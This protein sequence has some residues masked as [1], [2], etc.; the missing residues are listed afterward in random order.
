MDLRGGVVDALFDHMLIAQHQAFD[1]SRSIGSFS[2][3][4]GVVDTTSITLGRTIYRSSSSAYPAYGTLNVTGGLFRAGSMLLGD[5]ASSYDC[6]GEPYGMV[7]LSGSGVIE[8]N[9]DVTMGLR[10]G[11]AP[12]INATINVSNGTMTVTGNIMPADV[13][14]Y[15]TSNLNI[16][17]GQLYATNSLGDST[18]S[19][20]HGTLGL[21]KGAATFDNFNMNGAYATTTMVE[22]AGTDLEDF[23]QVTV[24]HQLELGGVLVVTNSVDYT[25]KIGDSW[26]IM[27]GTGTR[28]NKFDSEVL[29][30]GMNVTYTSNGFNLSI[31]A[32]GTLFLIQ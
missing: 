15:I 11:E 1:R 19:I 28:T 3:G 31:P 6:K 23:A 22:L 5:N 26:T 7:N 20:D 32:Q 24:N 4:A 21:I 27:T 10:N 2:M 8:V 13:S 18:F 30:E 17:G 14:E 12:D 16:A 9:G 25:P 29:L